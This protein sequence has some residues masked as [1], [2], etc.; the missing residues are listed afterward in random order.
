MLV[1]HLLNVFVFD[2]EKVKEF[3]KKFK[4][5]EKK[6]KYGQ[7]LFKMQIRAFLKKNS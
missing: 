4:V 2:N 3:D 5:K 6:I 7:E 1:V